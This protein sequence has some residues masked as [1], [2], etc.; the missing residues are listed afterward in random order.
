[1]SKR[2][3]VCADGTWN[4]IG[5]RFPTNVVKLARAITPIATDGT[6]QVVFYDQGVGTGNLLDKL[7]GGAFGNGLEQNIA[8]GYH[9]LMHNYA[10]GDE[11]FLFGVSRGAYTVR[12]LAGHIHKCGILHKANADR[13]HE[14]YALYRRTD[15]HPDDEAAKTFRASFSRIAE[16]KCLG[17]WDTVGALGVPVA[18]LRRLTRRKYEFHVVE[19]S[20]FVRNGFHAIAIDERRKTFKPS[21]WAKKEKPGQRVEQVWF[22]GAHTDIGGGNRGAGLSDIALL[23]MAQKARSCGLALDTQYLSAISHPDGNGRIHSK[24]PWFYRLLGTFTRPLGRGGLNEAISQEAVARYENPSMAYQPKNVAAYM[25][26][27]DHMV[28]GEKQ[29]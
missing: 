13:F 15:I 23:W 10:E 24:A 22:A 28:A 25:N 8:D 6:S 3:V 5:Q 7:T 14:A 9:F 18:G 1:M 26:D 12:S 21:I 27:P 11:I 2:I 17:V 29:P 16:I 4:W 20:R 19:L